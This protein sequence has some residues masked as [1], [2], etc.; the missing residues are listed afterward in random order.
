VAG[1]TDFTPEEWETMQKGATG[2]ALL[3]SMADANFFDTFKEA[4]SIGGYLNEARKNNQS[5]LVREL[6]EVRGTGF[7]AGS[8]AQVVESATLDALRSSMAALQ[9]KAP[10]EAPAYTTFVLTLAENVAKAAGG[11]LPPENAAIEKI[12]AALTT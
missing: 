4:G 11:V 1:K 10:D 6:A 5:Q 7:G 12:R 2:A 9:A 3:V 8:S